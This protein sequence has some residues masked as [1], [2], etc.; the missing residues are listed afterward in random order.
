MVKTLKIALNF[1]MALIIIG[2]SIAVLANP[3]LGNKGWRMVLIF[4][5]LVMLAGVNKRGLRGWLFFLVGWGLI[6]FGG[7]EAGVIIR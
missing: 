1:L 2:S 3:N 6:V 5:V 7:L 4:G